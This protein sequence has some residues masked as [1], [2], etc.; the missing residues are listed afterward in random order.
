MIHCAPLSLSRTCI[1]WQR[2]WLSIA[3]RAEYPE[4]RPIPPENGD[5]LPA[6]RHIQRP[7]AR[8]PESNT[9]LAMRTVGRASI[10]PQERIT[11]A[12]QLALEGGRASRVFFVAGI[13]STR[14]ECGEDGERTVQSERAKSFFDGC[15]HHL[16]EIDGH[17]G[18][19]RENEHRLRIAGPPL[20]AGLFLFAHVPRMYKDHASRGRRAMVRLLTTLSA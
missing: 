20:I 7:L 18:I 1:H 5:L 14:V 9:A 19:A 17:R 3:D 11:A 6:A 4:P 8:S 16:T 10:H 2:H 15:W 13:L 12:L